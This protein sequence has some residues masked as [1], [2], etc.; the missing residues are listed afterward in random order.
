ML[1]LRIGSSGAEVIQLQNLLNRH[2]PHFQVLKPDGIFGPRTEAA[3]RQFQSFAGISVDGTV[4]IKTWRAL[5]HGVTTTSDVSPVPFHD[6]IW[7]KIAA[8]EVGQREFPG[9]PANPRII[10]YHGATSLRATSDEVAWCS[11]FVNWCLKQAGI[12][13]TNS[14]AA[15]SWLHW[16]QMTCPRPGAITVV[17]KNTGQNHVSFYISETKD[18]YKLLGGNQAE[19]VRIS[20]YYKSHWLAQGHR[21][22]KLPHL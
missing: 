16:G 21:W 10:M 12:A 20:N 2:L 3:V 8:A 7:L 5:D 14:A 1:E 4:G 11:A 9:S 19:Q 22:P 18:F 17:R 6:A 13:G 15:T